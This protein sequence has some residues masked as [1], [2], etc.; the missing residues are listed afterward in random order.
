MTTGHARSVRDL[1]LDAVLHTAPLRVFA[2]DR[3]GTCT[4]SEG[5]GLSAAGVSPGEV[6]GANLWDLYADNPELVEA[7]RRPLRGETFLDTD[8]VG[9]RTFD[10]WYLP[11]DEDAG[12]VTSA[13]GISGDVTDRTRAQEDLQLYRAFVEASPQFIALARLDG[14]VLH[15]N[16]GGRR[17]AGIA[18]DVDVTATTIADY[19]TAEGL[20]AS[21][22]VEQPAVVRD[23]RYEGETTLRH[24]PTGEGIPVRVA[25][26]LVTDPATGVPLALATV[27]ADIREVVAGREAMQRQ[28]AHQRGLLV[29]LHEA[30][31]AE[32]QRIAGEI[33]DD[34]VQV[35]AAVNLRLQSF[36]RAVE[37]LLPPDRVADLAALDLAVRETTGRLRR[38]LVE[39]DPPPS[40][41]EDVAFAL[42]SAVRTALDGEPTTSDVDVQITGEPSS[43]VGRVLMRI[44][45]EALANVVKH[46]GAHSVRV[47]LREEPGEYVLRVLDDGAGVPA[48]ETPGP[49]HRGVRGMRE[50]AVS[51]GGTFAL[52]PAPGRGTVAE[53]RLPHLLGHP[54]QDLAG[55]VSRLFLEQTI[56]SITEGYTALD[57]QWRYV[58]VNLP[59]YRMLNRD[60]ADSLLGKVLWEEFEI[61]DDFAAAYRK[62]M[63]ERVAV[64]VT[65]YHRPWDKWIE[66]RI[67]PTSS[68]LS[69]FG[70]DVTLERRQAQRVDIGRAVVKAVT[71]PE[72]DA[73]RAS[74][75]AL[76]DRWP[77]R[78][79]QLLAPDGSTLAEVGE[80]L[81]GVG[82][83][84]PL[85]VSGTA[86][87]TAVMF[88][89]VD[90]VDDEMLQLIALRLAAGSPTDGS[91]DRDGSGRAEPGSGPARS[92]GHG[93][94]PS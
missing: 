83:S 79:V 9:D 80:V 68:G 20:A 67:M 29:H 24:W 8:R 55:G 87:G 17:M 86:V 23:G 77:L 69:I 76:V 53:A 14:S 91:T 75:A 28:V 16:P 32:R 89:E 94:D 2:Y 12:R 30:Q 66:N 33:H 18:A 7:M 34:T 21:I 62:A 85:A 36:R 22:E 26:F 41:G 46:A 47:E 19:L 88:G 45:R 52:S 37:P 73:V 65:G 74:L 56:E 11:L 60:P 43:I 35:M 70:R 1:V 27:Q 44:V 54:E 13:L 5:A 92:G 6:V 59:A 51:V 63:D 4:F 72:D 40:T 42:Q 64:R 25:S 38:L 90:P 48:G 61:G 39:L 82:R 93:P 3:D 15:V 49:L 57:D 31:E 71:G 81:D 84:V 50:R 58:Y 78:G 10:T